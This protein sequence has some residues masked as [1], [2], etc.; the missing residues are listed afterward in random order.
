MNQECLWYTLLLN[1]MR[2]VII[3][4]LDGA[5]AAMLSQSCKVERAGYM[6]RRD[7]WIYP[8]VRTVYLVARLGYEELFQY[9]KN[10]LM[11]PT[12]CRNYAFGGDASVYPF[13]KT[14][15]S[16][17][18]ISLVMSMSWSIFL[19]IGNTFTANDCYKLMK[20]TEPEF[21]DRRVLC[22]VLKRGA[23]VSFSERMFRMA[24][25]DG[26]PEL[27]EYMHNIYPNF[28]AAWFNQTDE[29]YYTVKAVAEAGNLDTFLFLKKIAP[30]LMESVLSPESTFHRERRMNKGIG[31]G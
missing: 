12:E 24:L 5:S 6:K 21:Y 23:P 11:S 22:E 15:E 19:L 16:P 13:I 9:I 20:N 31:L 17:V 7:P 30:S 3:T 26:T 14:I 25:T 8:S 4:M 10:A 1:D 2:D 28:I 27:C 29:L 18:G